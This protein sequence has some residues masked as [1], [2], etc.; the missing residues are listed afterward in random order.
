[1]ESKGPGFGFVSKYSSPREFP[2]FYSIYVGHVSPFG[3]VIGPPLL[4]MSMETISGWLTSVTDQ[5]D[6]SPFFSTTINGERQS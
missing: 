1:M 2:L 6:S 4:F 5:D 3:I